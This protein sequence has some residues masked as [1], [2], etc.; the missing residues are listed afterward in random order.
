MGSRRLIRFTPGYDVL[1]LRRTRGFAKRSDYFVCALL[2]CTPGSGSVTR[3]TS[4]DCVNLYHL[5][6]STPANEDGHVVAHAVWDTDN[7]Q[8]RVVG[9]RP[10]A[11]GDAQRG[12]VGGLGALGVRAGESHGTQL[13]SPTTRSLTWMWGACPGSGLSAS[14]TPTNSWPAHRETRNNP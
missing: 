10:V 4:V 9:K 8:G 6:W 14:T 3:D 11:A 5:D 1:C 13:I 12:A 7:R 2:A